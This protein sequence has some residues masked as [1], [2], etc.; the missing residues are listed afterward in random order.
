MNKKLLLTAIVLVAVLAVGAI[1]YPKL[2]ARYAP[3]TPPTPPAGETTA[4]L[5]SDFTVTDRNGG[6]VKLSDFFGKPVIVNFWATWCDPC[7][8]ELPAFQSAFETYGEEIE[9]VMVNVGGPRDT[10]D[11]VWAFADENGYTFPAYFDTDNEAAIAYG[12]RSIPMTVLIAA[13]G[14]VADS[15]VG[16]LDEETLAG[17]MDTLRGGEAK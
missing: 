10:A 2:S 9:F 4:V 13:D 17:Y 11:T 5:A 3:V 8:M 1:L 15:F 16:M 14:T 6:A 12:V 7:R